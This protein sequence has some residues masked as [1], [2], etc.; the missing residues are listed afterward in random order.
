M[1]YSSLDS[2]DT[3]TVMV[4][5][6]GH[7]IAFYQVCQEAQSEVFIFFFNLLIDFS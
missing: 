7:P 6:E 2:R 5:D 4:T 1:G 3:E